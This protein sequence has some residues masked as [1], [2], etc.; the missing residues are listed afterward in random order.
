MPSTA[1]DDLIVQILT[2]AF[3]NDPFMAWTFDDPATQA[4]CLETWWRYVVEHPSDGA[5]VS[6]AEDRSS[7]ALWRSPFVPQGSP[8]DGVPAGMAPFIAMLEPLVGRRLGVVLEMFGQI[9]RA[10]PIEPHWYLSAVGTLPAMQGRGRG[11]VLLQ[12]VLDH[13]DQEGLPIYLESSNPR[14]LDFYDRLGFRV[15]STIDSPDN[16]VHLTAMW[17]DPLVG[18]PYGG[19]GR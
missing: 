6:I 2:Q 16:L 14:N 7:A 17:R 5:E 4:S 9:E 10:H 19:R 11:R 12:P 15:T 13:C 8:D 18:Q 1:R 3:M